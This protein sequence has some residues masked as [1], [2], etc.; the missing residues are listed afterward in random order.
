MRR[1]AALISLV[2]LLLSLFVYLPHLGHELIWDSKP[3]IGENDLLRQGFSPVA[4]FRSGYWETTSQRSDGGYDYYRPLTI[5]SFMAEKALWGLSP[6]GL[7]LVNLLLFIVALFVLRAFLRRQDAGAEGSWPGAAE[8]AVLLFALFPPHLDN[9][10]WVVGR[11]DLLMFLFG[12]LSL[13]LFDRF[14]ERRSPWAG[15]AALFSY[16]LALLAKESALFFL[17][18]IPL[19]ELVRR[20]RISLPLFI[21]PLL[22]TLGYW[23]LKSVV[24]GRG[25]LPLRPFPGLPENFA[26]LAGALG[27]Y[28]RSLVFPFRYDMFLPLDAVRSAP[29]LVLGAAAALLL[30][31]GLAYALRDATGAV[32][33]PAAADSGRRSLF[34]GT[35]FWTAPFLGGALLMVFTPIHPFSLSTRYLLLP[36]VGWAWFLGHSLQAL[37]PAAKRAALLLL[38]AA[39]AFSIAAHSRKYS[40]EG[41]FWKTALDSRP[42]ESFFLYKYAGELLRS[43]EAIRAE[44]L[45][46]RA[47]RAPLKA[48]TAAGIALHLS[49]IAFAQARYG[50]SLEWLEKAATLRLNRLH[51]RRRRQRLLAL[52]TARNDLAAAEAAVLQARPLPENLVRLHLSFAAWDKARQA[53]RSLSA[54][55]VEAWLRIVQK[56]ENAFAASGPAGRVRFFM[57]RGNF[58]AAWKQWPD[59]DAPGVAAQLQAARMALLAGDEEEGRMRIARLVG[60]YGNDHRIVNSAAN[61]LYDLQRGDEA[62][63]LYRRSLRLN[64]SQPAVRERVVF[65]ERLFRPGPPTR[66]SGDPAID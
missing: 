65:L 53:A 29:L 56:E 44:P 24:I 35:W 25:G 62:L 52:H 4:P 17:P 11:C 34:L 13:L 57:Q 42:G 55:Q 7:K 12:L 26:N 8:A 66:E 21:P 37:K 40:G 59:R 5:L 30:A 51:E 19:H 16:L 60:E 46:R 47:L 23:L 36:A 38:L 61:L 6:W 45:L 27:Y 28:A 32:R 54:P 33:P 20:R 14:L 22:L 9:I 31:L 58:A 1:S 39:S 3:I 2:L 43:G 15:L 10:L 48:S 49:D 50:Q 18:L 64:P 63:D 41:E